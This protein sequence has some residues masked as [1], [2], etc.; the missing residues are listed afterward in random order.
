MVDV[1][2][3]GHVASLIN[4]KAANCSG[5]HT[6]TAGGCAAAGSGKQLPQL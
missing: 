5:G 2:E 1:G 4:A 6:I 3:I